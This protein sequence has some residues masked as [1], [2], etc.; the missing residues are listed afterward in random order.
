MAKKAE[1]AGRG[2]IVCKC[3]AEYRTVMKI[4]AKDIVWR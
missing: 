2:G 3:L 1:D 4:V